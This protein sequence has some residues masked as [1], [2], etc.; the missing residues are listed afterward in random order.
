MIAKDAVR[1]GNPVETAGR[2]LTPVLRIR[3]TVAGAD[4]GVGGFGSVEPL[5]LV[6]EEAGGTFFYAFD[7]LKGWDWVSARLEV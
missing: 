4:P 1:L 7:L 3:Y 6:L 2:V 5:G